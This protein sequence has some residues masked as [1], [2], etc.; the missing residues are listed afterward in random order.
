MG[1]FNLVGFLYIKELDLNVRG[2]FI[3]VG[4]YILKM[5]NL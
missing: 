2:Y 3:V 4:R 1:I 5:L